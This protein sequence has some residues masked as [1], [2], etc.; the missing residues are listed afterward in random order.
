MMEVLQSV[1]FGA[2]QPEGAYYVLAD[3]SQLP[4]PQAGW[5]STR[6]A[7]WMVAEIGVA[8]VPGSVFYSLPGYGERM[9][10]FAFPKKLDTLRA[11]GECMA[12]MAG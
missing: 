11:A 3:Y 7:R 10:R 6:F 4:I 8:V 12:R 1:G 2:L 9:L 5:D